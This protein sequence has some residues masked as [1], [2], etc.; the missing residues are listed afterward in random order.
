M[1]LLRKIRIM[2]NSSCGAQLQNL[3]ST[4]LQAIDS[5]YDSFLIANIAFNGFL[6][7]TTI[8][9]NIVTIHALRKTYSLSKPLRT[10]L[11]NLAI[12]DL[13]VGFVG[14][15]L[16]IVIMAA[17]L[18]SDVPSL[19]IYDA[20]DII[21]N[22]LY[23][24]SLFGILALS[25]DRF[26]AIQTR[27]RYENLVTQK[28]VVVVIALIWMLTTIFVPCSFL[29]LP[30]ETHYLISDIT[31]LFF[32]VATTL[33]S[34]KIYLTSRRHRI[35]I[36]AQIQQVVENDDMITNARL[37]KSAQTSFWIYLIFWVCFLPNVF[38]SIALNVASGESLIIDG[39]LEVSMTLVFL[40]SS[41]NP[42]IYCSKMRHVRRTVMDT[43]RNL[44]RRG[45]V[46]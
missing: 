1:D 30:R 38:I 25:T 6:C 16:Y 39:L 7:Y 34:G 29:L 36:Q 21:W 45:S 14:Q 13:G 9:L 46:N 23:L 2:N 19:A 32:F 44:F 20:S 22:L 3:S 4:G 15:P 27:L 28:R 5:L 17:E 26:F 31:V 11:L 12:S 24:F 40:N 10:L 35:Q 42:V 41:L 43:L 18:R 33:S 37:K 8:M